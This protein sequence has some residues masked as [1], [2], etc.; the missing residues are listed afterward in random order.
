MVYS[1]ECGFEAMT[2]VSLSKTHKHELLLLIRVYKWEPARAHNTNYY[3]DKVA[4][5]TTASDSQCVQRRPSG[6]VP[7]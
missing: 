5:Q 7:K 1:S 4:N 2:P 3:V 6:T